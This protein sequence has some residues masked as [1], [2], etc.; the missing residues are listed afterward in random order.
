MLWSTLRAVRNARR[1]R[2]YIV[3]VQLVL[4]EPPQPPGTF[5]KFSCRQTQTTPT[6]E[7]EGEDRDKEQEG[8]EQEGNNVIGRGEGAGADSSSKKERSKK[9]KNKGTGEGDSEAAGGETGYTQNDA[10]AGCLATMRVLRRG[11][12]GCTA[13]G[14]DSSARE[15]STS[16][17]ISKS[18]CMIR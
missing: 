7:G 5:P 13:C 8:K 9:T 17:T 16:H 14:A 6:R 4:W 11:S 18:I 1:Q 3:R 2:C 10:A 15:K 12:L